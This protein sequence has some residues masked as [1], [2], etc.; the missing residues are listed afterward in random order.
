MAN[1]TNG[2]DSNTLLVVAGIAVLA[3][4]G[5]WWF[6]VRKPASAQALPGTGTGTGTGTG[7]ATLTVA[8]TD[9]K[10]QNLTRLLSSQGQGQGQ[11]QQ[12]TQ[13]QQPV[14][15]GAGTQYP[16]G[17]GTQYPPPDPN[18]PVV[19]PY[20]T[21]SGGPQYF[22]TSGWGSH[23]I[24][25]AGGGYGGGGMATMMMAS[26]LL[27]APPPGALP[28]LPTA[29]TPV[30]KGPGTTYPL[31]GSFDAQSFVA[32][33]GN[34][35]VEPPTS[36]TA[37][38]GTTWIEVLN[39]STSA[40]EG[41]VD[42]SNLHAIDFATFVPGSGGPVPMPSGASY[43]G[44]LYTWEPLSAAKLLPDNPAT[45]SWLGNTSTGKVTVYTPYGRVI[46]Y[47]GWIFS[48]STNTARS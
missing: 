29:P 23:I 34:S 17:A 25:A 1:G 35:T 9:T 10:K 22:V 40:V 38:G 8:T 13:A 14:D 11:A 5:Y 24:G 15:T 33:T 46:L 12:Q 21:T 47:P 19:S 31:V 45:G 32:S 41:W 39:P 2:S 4:A 44:Q 42:A 27:S 6:Y 28:T 3:G 37:I 20:P 48:F 43:H 30:Y 26:P 18:Q 36:N 16:P 7:N